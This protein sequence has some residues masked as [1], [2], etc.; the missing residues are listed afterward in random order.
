MGA[1][2]VFERYK[3]EKLW[4]ERFDTLKEIVGITETLYVHSNSSVLEFCGFQ[5][6]NTEHRE[7]WKMFLLKQNFNLAI[8]F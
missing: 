1:Y 2:I 5:V 4:Q 3:N 6:M 8:R 7:N